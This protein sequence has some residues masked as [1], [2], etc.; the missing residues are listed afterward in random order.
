MLLSFAS[1]RHFVY[2]DLPCHAL[3]FFRAS[4]AKASSRAL[5]PV[6][7]RLS[8]SLVASVVVVAGM[9]VK[10]PIAATDAFPA[11]GTSFLSPYG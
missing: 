8:Y 6:K 5:P 7:V 1:L 4:A 11:F 2:P 3:P 9:E 10:P